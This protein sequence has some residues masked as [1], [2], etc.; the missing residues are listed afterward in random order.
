MNN[1]M[2]EIGELQ[3]NYKKLVSENR[4]SKKAMCELIIPFRDKYGLS[5]LQALQIARAELSIS[6]ICTIFNF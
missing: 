4:L 1:I 3:D 2:K 5:D 6:D